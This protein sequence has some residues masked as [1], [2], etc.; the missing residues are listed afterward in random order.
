MAKWSGIY[1]D[2]SLKLLKKV[3]KELEK[4]REEESRVVPESKKY[5]F[6][7]KLQNKIKKWRKEMYNENDR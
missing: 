6:A 3:E 4:A 2:D 1:L 7:V 5:A